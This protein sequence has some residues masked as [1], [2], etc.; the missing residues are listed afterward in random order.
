MKTKA[1]KMK[2][3]LIMLSISFYIVSCCPTQIYPVP[4]RLQYSKTLEGNIETFVVDNSVSDGYVYINTIDFNKKTLFSFYKD[5]F[6]N[7]R[8]QTID[9][10]DSLK[11]VVSF[12]SNGI[13]VKTIQTHFTPTY[14][15]EVDIIGTL[16]NEYVALW[17]SPNYGEISF[18]IN[19]YKRKGDIK[20]TNNIVATSLYSN[21][22]GL[23]TTRN[24]LIKQAGLTNKDTIYSSLVNLEYLPY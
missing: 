23:E 18:Y 14:E 4:N 12:Y 2:P 16:N 22:L 9:F 15:G 10:Q 3:I 1:S 5:Y 19:S 24:K 21:N 17:A 11:A 20:M 13:I 7:E 8:V 6:E